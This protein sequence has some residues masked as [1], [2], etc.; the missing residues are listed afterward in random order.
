MSRVSGK[1]TKTEILVRKSLFSLGFRFRKNDPRYPGKPDI[2]LPKFQTAIFIHGCFWHGHENCKHSTLPSSNT[3][4]WKEKINNNIIRDKR[5]ID[6]L[7][8]HGW[9]TIV[10]WGCEIET[11]DKREIRLKSLAKELKNID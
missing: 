8:E 11:I 7:H 2:I 4:Y 3:K 9:K 5:N 6:E 1:E 10:I